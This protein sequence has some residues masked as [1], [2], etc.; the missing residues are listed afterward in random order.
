[1]P[2][3]TCLHER[4]KS[5]SLTKGA[6]QRFACAEYIEGGQRILHFTVYLQYKVAVL[7][8][9]VERKETDSDHSP[10]LVTLHVVHPFMFFSPPSPPGGSPVPVPLSLLTLAGRRVSTIPTGLCPLASHRPRMA[11]D[12]GGTSTCAEVT[13]H[14]TKASRILANPSKDVPFRSYLR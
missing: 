4:T 3:T 7:T 13:Y 1:M 8:Y 12:E 10:P 9:F 5:H 2:Y 14:C 11:Y 6:T